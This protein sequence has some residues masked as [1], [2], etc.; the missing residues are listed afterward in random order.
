[1]GYL[2]FRI[3]LTAFC[4]NIFLHVILVDSCFN[5]LI[6]LSKYFSSQFMSQQGIN[7]SGSFWIM[8]N[9]MSSSLLCSLWKNSL[10]WL[11]SLSSISIIITPLKIL[12]VAWKI[13][14]FFIIYII[15]DTEKFYKWYGVV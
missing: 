11:W 8:E 7:F 15:D 6:R 3:S 1:M 13:H 2:D 5:L 10:I 4:R 12:C 9:A 14:N